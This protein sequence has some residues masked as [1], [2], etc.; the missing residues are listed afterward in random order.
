MTDSDFHVPLKER[1]YLR[2]QF[3]VENALLRAF[4]R[5]KPC[6]CQTLLGRPMR[7]C[8][9]HALDKTA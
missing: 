2:V 3:P 6:G 9:A 8:I 1:F 4:G 7:L 5:R